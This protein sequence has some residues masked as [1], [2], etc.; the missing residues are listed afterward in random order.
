[1]ISK[2]TTIQVEQHKIST[3][4][5]RKILLPIVNGDNRDNDY[6]DVANNHW[7][8]VQYHQ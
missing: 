5:C 3:F 7:V 6:R 4:S 2:P 8:I 1:M